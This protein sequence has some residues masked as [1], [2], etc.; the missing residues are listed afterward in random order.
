ME[1]LLILVKVN[2]I[3]GSKWA[4]GG[5]TTIP[6]LQPADGNGM[7]WERFFFID[8]YSVLS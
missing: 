3:K 4:A 7:G 8:P 2:W 6:C 5:D 1:L